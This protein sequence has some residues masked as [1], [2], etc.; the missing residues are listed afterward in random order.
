VF[1][2]GPNLAPGSQDITGTVHDD[3]MQ[4]L[5]A[6]VN[7]SQTFHGLAGNDDLDGGGGDDTLEGGA[8][9]DDLDGGAGTDTALYA[10]TIDATEI[11]ASGGGWTVT[12][13][14]GNGTD[15]LSNIEFVDGAGAGQF[16]LVGNGGFATIQAAINAASAGDTIIV[17]GGTYNESIN[18]NKDVTLLS[19]G[20]VTINGQGTNPGFSFAVMITAAGA[21][22][23]DT[24]QGFTV[25]AG[26][27][28]T[29]GIFVGPIA[30]VRIEGNVI[31]GDATAT[32]NHLHQGLLVQAGVSNLTIDNNTFGGTAD[33]LIY[34]NGTPDGGPASTNVNV[35]NNTFSGNAVVGAVL[36]STGNVTSNTFGG[37]LTGAGLS[38]TVPGN[39]VAS[40]IF[41]SFVGVVDIATADQ[42]FNLNTNPTA[43]NLEGQSTVGGVNFTGNTLDNEIT[44]NVHPITLDDDFDDTLSGLAGDDILNG[45]GGNDVLEGG[46]DDD[47]VDGG[48]GNQD[49][50]TFSG[51]VG[52]YTFEEVSAN[53]IRVIDQR[54]GSP[55]GVD[56][57]RDVEFFDF[58]NGTFSSGAVFNFAATNTNDV[59]T[60]DSNPNNLDGMGGDDQIFGNGGD[61]VLTGGNGND[62]MNG[63]TGADTMDG[64]DNNDQMFGDDGNDTMDGGFGDDRMNGQDDDDLMF[65]GAGD[66]LMFGGSGDDN[67]FGDDGNDRMFG[68]AGADRMTGGAGND[69][70]TGGLG[71]DQMVGGTG[72]DRFD[73]NALAE[74][75]RGTNRDV[76]FFERTEGDKI[77]VTNI[78]ANS[79][80]GGNQAFTFIGGAGFSAAGQMRFSGGILQGDVNGDGTADFEVRVVGALTGGDMFL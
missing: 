30:N 23:G 6:G 56:L 17:A 47:E 73:F 15:T 58:A 12:T 62:V 29:A 26:A 7:Q 25:E 61:D 14:G 34:V 63:G 39:T 51:N 54:G 28:E 37:A 4:E 38:L 48:A 1:A 27:Q 20:A 5:L 65:G 69:F 55:D 76:V 70:I 42:V 3:H 10:E 8:N 21:T 19:S 33:Q 60:G 53:E 16:V 68:D 22:F 44:G 32:T 75:V 31:N 59:L 43:Q 13:N 36:G 40:N 41:T 50:A 71:R 18:V 78:D 77:D 24:G 80:V 45:L 67:M 57:V 9:N 2:Y 79:T 66:D 46:A 35:T 64:G 49:H 74:S 11:A 52:D 72:A